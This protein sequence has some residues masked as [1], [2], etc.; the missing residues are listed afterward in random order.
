MFVLCCEA[1]YGIYLQRRCKYVLSETF[2]HNKLLFS[3]GFL[4]LI[5]DVFNKNEFTIV[6]DLDPMYYRQIS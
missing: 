1:L 6:W 4:L 5:T 2:W 3:E